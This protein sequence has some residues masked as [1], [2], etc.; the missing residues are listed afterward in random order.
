MQF[1]DMGF[2]VKRYV[3]LMWSVVLCDKLVL[4][5]NRSLNTKKIG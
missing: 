3:C 2:E 5:S 4:S 1:R